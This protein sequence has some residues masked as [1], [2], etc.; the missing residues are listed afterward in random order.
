MIE[1]FFED[2][3]DVTCAICS[4]VHFIIKTALFIACIICI[5]WGYGIIGGV[6]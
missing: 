5:L 3:Y 4:S 6:L 1:K 2:L